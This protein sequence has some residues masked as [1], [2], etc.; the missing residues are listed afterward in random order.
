MKDNSKHTLILYLHYL[1]R[2]KN[3]IR[4]N[5]LVTRKKSETSMPDHKGDNK[6]EKQIDESFPS[7]LIDNQLLTSA[8]QISNH[9]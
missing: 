3:L 9:F 5:T 4:N 7:L 1:G 6:H 8:K 2:L